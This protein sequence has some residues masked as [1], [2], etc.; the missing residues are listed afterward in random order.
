MVESLV[1]N[2]MTSSKR[3]YSKGTRFSLWTFCWSKISRLIKFLWNFAN[4]GKQQPIDIMFFVTCRRFLPWSWFELMKWRRSYWCMKRKSE[5]DTFDTVFWM[6]SVYHDRKKLL[7]L[8]LQKQST[9]GHDWRHCGTFQ[10]AYLPSDVANNKQLSAQKEL[11][12]VRF[13]LEV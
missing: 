3:C 12:W 7:R 9:G 2:I 4:F 1:Y 10:V 11:L 6:A 8:K 13:G 5:L